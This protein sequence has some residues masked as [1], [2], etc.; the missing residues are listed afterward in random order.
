M[1]WNHKNEPD[2]KTVS[3]LQEKLGVSSTIATLLAQRNINNFEQAKAFFRP[4]QGQIQ[5]PFL[6]LDMDKAVQRL[7]KTIDSKEH[8]MVY[9][10]YDV[11]GTTS[12]SMLTHFLRNLGVGVTPYI[13]NR[14][15]EGY[16]LSKI[17]VETAKADNIKLMV[18]VDCGIKAIKQIEYAKGLGIEV[19]ICDHHNPGDSL[20]KALAILDPKRNDCSYPNKELCACGV[21]F[22]LIHG[23]IKNQGKNIDEIISYL[24]FVAVATAADI[25]PI[26]GE[27]RA[28]TFLGLHQLNNSSRPGF[29]A[30]KREKY[31]KQIISDIAFGI[32]PRINAAGRMKHGLYAVE[33]LLAESNEEAKL[34]AS[35][36]ENFNTS[37]RE[38]EKEIT[39][40]AL[41]LIK[42]KGEENNASTVVFAP[43]WHK[44][45]IGIVASRL[46]DEHYRPTL[47]FTKANEGILAASARS[48]RD[49]N[50]YNAIDS[51]SAHII[52][53]GGHKYAAGVTIR[54]KK[55]SA[56][57]AAFEKVVDETITSSQKEKVIDIDLKLSFAEITPKLMRLIKQMEP[58]GPENKRPVFYTE[59]VFITGHAKLVGPAKDHLKA[60]FV[61]GNG[62]P[63]SA[64]GFGLGKKIKMLQSNKPISISYTVEENSWQG[65]VALQL[66]LKDIQ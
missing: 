30:L 63:I 58:F 11:D 54:E 48:V 6:M 39:K 37:R 31:S 21:V 22:K 15:T 16:G 61:H 33:L 20:P 35:E 13:P 25:V 29:K 41:S 65:N 66:N 2:S 14:Y 8:I 47:V 49:F 4:D 42:T 52:Q 44:G 12:V 19:I 7:Q 40:E 18:V 1:R 9:G 38:V 50:V 34:A 10:D 57:K 53:F 3:L 36:I 60:N 32:A 56:F 28:L 24:D 17:G 45:V 46:I 27:N 51:C 64:I 55:Y 43:H 26:N 23:L 59:G 5:D 62:G